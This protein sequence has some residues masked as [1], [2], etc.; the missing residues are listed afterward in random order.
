MTKR[1]SD[2]CKYYTETRNASE[3]CRRAGYSHA[4]CKSKSHLLLKNEEILE[5]V[6]HLTDKHF[7]EHFSRLA[8][9]ALKGLEDVIND[10]ENRSTQ[11]RASMYVLNVTGFAPE[12]EEREKTKTVFEVLIPP[13]YAEYGIE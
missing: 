4:Y 8:L 2:F 10:G 11:L 13:E 6:T 12:P 9:I 3:A 5:Q 7:K 1:Q